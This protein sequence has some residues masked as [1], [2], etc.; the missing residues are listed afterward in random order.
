MKD[1]ELLRLLRKQEKLPASWN[2]L[3]SDNYA[4]K[5]VEKYGINVSWN[6]T[7][8]GRVWRAWNKDNS[9]TDPDRR[10][11]ICKAALNGY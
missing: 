2:P 11:A 7:H 6:S 9:A 5:L 3:E 10:R 1:K 8:T 4:A